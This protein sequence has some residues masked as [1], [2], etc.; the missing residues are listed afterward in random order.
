MAVPPRSFRLLVAAF[1]IVALARYSSVAKY[2]IAV[3]TA[4]M[5]THRS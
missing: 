1:L 4:P 2:T 5:I 3:R